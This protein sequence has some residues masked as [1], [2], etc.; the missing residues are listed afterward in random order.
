M[1]DVD[2]KRWADYIEEIFRVYDIKPSLVLDLGCGTGSF[3]LE[4]A[5]RRYEMIGV[6]LSPEML[7][8]ARQKCID[9]NVDVLLLNQDMS[10]FELYG[11]VDAAV[12]LL[13]SVNYI[14][15]KRDVK[16]LFKLVSN[17]VNPGGIFIFDINSP[18]KFEKVLGNN[19][20]YS[21][22]DSITYI[23]QNS[24]DKRRKICEFDLT[25]F[26]EENGYYKRCD[27]FHVERA[28]SPEDITKFIRYSGMKLLAMYD[29][30]SLKPPKKSSE[31]IFVV[32]R[33]I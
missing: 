10:R 15:G 18:Y 22:D 7:A 30:L 19:V 12:C 11:T 16:R 27:E 1:Q 33:K 32:C 2:Y 20:F 29:D 9:A 5:K 26:I 4:M 8:C 17:Y 31:R 3:C 24:Y 6:D 25:F 23:W 13:D 28:Y 14:T 21:V